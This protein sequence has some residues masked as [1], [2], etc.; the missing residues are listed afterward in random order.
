[1]NMSIEEIITELS[2][3][4]SFKMHLLL[5]GDDDRKFFQAA[6]IGKEK[7]NFV[8]VWGA[9]SV[10][11]LIRRIDAISAQGVFTPTLGV[12]DRD[13]RIALGTLHSSPNLLASDLRDMECMMFGSPHLRQL[14]LN[15]DRHL[16]LWH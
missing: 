3:T 12:I 2:M 10:T 8:C 9:D 5:E 4:Y 6:L 15:S 7:V 1:M 16:R 13:Y 14:F 11:E